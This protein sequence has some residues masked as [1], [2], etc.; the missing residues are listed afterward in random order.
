VLLMR[1][2]PT[3]PLKSSG[4][5]ATGGSSNGRW[6]WI[7]EDKATMSTKAQTPSERRGLSPPWV[8]RTAGIN[9]AARLL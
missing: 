8:C 6:A 2:K 5:P 4:R 7:L 1:K 3:R 9:P